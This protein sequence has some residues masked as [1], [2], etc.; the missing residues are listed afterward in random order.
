MRPFRGLSVQVITQDGPLKL[1]HDPDVDP[2]SEPRT[3]QRYIEA[4]TGATFRVK[5][6]V[7]KDFELHTLGCCDAVQITISYDGQECYWY[8]HL[9]R[10]SIVCE[11]SKGKPAEHT[12]SRI[13]NF[14]QET[15]QWKQGVT[16]FGALHMSKIHC[17]AF[18]VPS[19]NP[20][21]RGDHRFPNFLV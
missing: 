14:C 20:V 15:H 16:S 3:R 12:F 8:T 11:W 9:T 1:H 13:P 21:Y 19:S 4:V 18:Q 10:A 7:H 5:I 6:S 2:S 17:S